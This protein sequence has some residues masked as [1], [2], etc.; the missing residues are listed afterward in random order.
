MKLSRLFLAFTALAATIAPALAIDAFQLGG[1]A[2]GVPSTV[3]YKFA[4]KPAIAVFVLGPGNLVYAKVTADNGKNWVDWTPISMD[5]VN[6][7]PSCAARNA[8]QI[9][10]IARGPNNSIYWN[11]FNVAQVKWTGWLDLGGKAN[12]DPSL[13]ATKE[14]NKTQLRIFSRGASNHLFMNT[15]TDLWSDWKDLDGTI[16]SR[17]S[18]A[19]VANLGAHC[20][21]SSKGNV[22]QVT[23]ITHQTGS[24]VVVEDLGG[25]VSGKVSAVWAGN[26]MHVF[27]RGPGDSLWTNEWSGS[28]SGWTQTEQ[29]IG[30]A[31]GCTIDAAAKAWCASVSK[32]GTVLMNRL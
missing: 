11:S 19:A 26:A 21:D 24:S 3:S 16:G 4:G 30:S 5:A 12:S 29:M 10:C 15:L 31:P 20:Y 17:F 8:G 1:A 22:L 2:K 27:A 9:D 25:S 14:G 18:C 13:V 23:D 6:G 32:D 28:W 7:D